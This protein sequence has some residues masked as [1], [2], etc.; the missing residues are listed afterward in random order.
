MD[1]CLEQRRA[2]WYDGEHGHHGGECQQHDLDGVQPRSSGT[3]SHI[4]TAATDGMV[5]PMLAT[6]E[7]NARLRLIWI[8]SRRA[9]RAAARV[10]GSR[11]NS[12]MTTPTNETGSP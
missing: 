4:D 8:R 9:A 3:D 5:R 10:S 1:T 11:I 12:A 6:A 7:P 2:A